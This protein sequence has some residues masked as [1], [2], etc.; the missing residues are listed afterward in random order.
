MKGLTFPGDRE[1]ALTEFPDP[2]PGMGE[3][4]VE[5]KASGMCGSDLHGYRRSK[6]E[7]AAL[8]SPFQCGPLVCGHE[9]CGIV[10]AVGPGVPASVGRIGD[11]VM[12]HHYAGC[13]ACNHCRSGWTQMCGCGAVHVYGINDHGAHAK[14]I[15]VPAF[16]LVPLP[17]ALSFAAGAAISCGTGTAYG[18]LR[19]LNLSGHDTLAVFGQGP[20]GL[21]ATQL[22]KAMGA[23]VIALDISEQRL[24]LARTFGADFTV[25]PAQ[26]DPVA[27]I[28][29][30]T[31]GEG[32]DLSLDTSGS[33]AARLSAVQCLKAWGK[34]CMVGEGSEL[35][36]DV[37]PD[38]LRKQVTV[39]GSWTFSTVLQ[40]ECAR[41]IVERG[42]DGD[43]LFTHRWSLD[44]AAEAYRLFDQQ[45][46]GK[47][48]FIF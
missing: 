45:A 32:S 13:G 9:P 15:K 29:D 48:V 42:V 23:R 14:Y 18:G 47:G 37:S 5:I 27:A 30:L 25:N 38:L 39:M 11:R 22:A 16:T 17:D 10:A 2:T 7:A 6:D 26:V 46:T 40:A 4:V 3:V 44:Q 33:P 8:H 1:V 24:A 43:A 12:V 21:A 19:K 41:F 35:R 36:L 20:V 28:K 31:R 34:A